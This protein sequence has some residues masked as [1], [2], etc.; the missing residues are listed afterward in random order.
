M[1]GKI[2]VRVVFVVE[3]IQLV[4]VGI[5]TRYVEPNLGLFGRIEL[6]VERPDSNRYGNVQE[7][8]FFLNEKIWIKILFIF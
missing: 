6:S 5:A 4:E 2:L 8:L 1:R 7:I 3:A